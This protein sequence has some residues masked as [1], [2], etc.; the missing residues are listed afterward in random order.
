MKWT[1][2][3]KSD[4]HCTWDNDLDEK[5]TYTTYRHSKAYVYRVSQ[6]T[7]ARL[8]MLIALPYLV[9]KVSYQH[10]PKFQMLHSYRINLSYWRL[11]I[12]TILSCGK[13]NN[14]LLNEPP[15]GWAPIS[16][17]IRPSRSHIRHF[18]ATQRSSSYCRCTSST[19]LE[20]VL[21]NCWIGRGGPHFWPPR[22]HTPNFRHT[23]NS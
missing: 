22:L 1:P 17:V 12:W 15:T 7:P 13:F 20:L 5:R 19:T 6:E 16:F 2:E 18:S 21:W 9:R 14:R 10:D 11:T 4:V 23:V 8:R 3:N